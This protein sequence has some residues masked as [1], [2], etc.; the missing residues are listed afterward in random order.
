MRTEATS[1]RT[2]VAARPGTRVTPR[3]AATR[4]SFAVHSLAI[5]STRVRPLPGADHG[6]ARVGAGRDP[7][8]PGEI[9]EVDGPAMRVW[10]LRPD[11]RQERVVD[12]VLEGDA[13]VAGDLAAREESDHGDVQ[14]PGGQAL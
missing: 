7:A 10:M 13:A 2:A 4:P 14:R 9:V 11:C 5:R 6:V 3:P 1:G 8:L 12:Q